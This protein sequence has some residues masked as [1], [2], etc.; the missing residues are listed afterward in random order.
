MSV[1]KKKKKKKKTD[2]GFAAR[3]IGLIFNFHELNSR[4]IDVCHLDGNST[5]IFVLLFGH[6]RQAR[7]LVRYKEDAFFVGMFLWLAKAAL[8]ADRET[9]IQAQVI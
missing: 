7:H 3:Y 1:F 6:C 5:V 9:T 4:V 8:S 2:N